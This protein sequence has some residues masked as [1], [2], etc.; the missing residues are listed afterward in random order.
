M[1]ELEKI[2]EEIKK[3]RFVLAVIMS[4]KS[5]EIKKTCMYLYRM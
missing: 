1:Q 2:L 5:S 3:K 4:V